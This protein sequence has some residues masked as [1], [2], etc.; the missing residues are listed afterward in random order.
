[1]KDKLR[2]RGSYCQ[3][4][5]IMIQNSSILLFPTLNISGFYHTVIVVF[6]RILMWG[7]C[8]S[9]HEMQ[10]LSSS[11]VICKSCLETAIY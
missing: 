1:M 3:S 11:P 2:Y 7:L 9:Q 5:V 4:S 10:Y 8:F 6:C